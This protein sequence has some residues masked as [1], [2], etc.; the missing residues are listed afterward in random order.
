[1]SGVDSISFEG[2]EIEAMKHVKMARKCIDALRAK[3]GASGAVTASTQM[4]VSDHAYVIALIGPGIA[5]A[6]IVAGYANHLAPSINQRAISDVPDFVS[7][8][9]IRSRI[10]T[11]G[12]GARSMQ[13]FWPT[14][15][16]A[17]AFELSDDPAPIAR[18][19]VEPDA[20]LEAQWKA[21]PAGFVPAQTMRVVPTMY[22]GKMRQVVQC[23]LGFGREPERSR[24]D[25]EPPLLTRYG[26]DAERQNVPAY[27]RQVAQ[28]GRVVSY[29]WSFARTHGITVGADDTL[30][31]I[32]ISVQRGVIAMQLPTNEVTRDPR[33]RAKLE[34]MGDAAGLT[35]LDAFGAWP[36]GEPFPT[37]DA[38]EQARRGG[39]VMQ[40]LAPAALDPMYENYSAYS[41]AMGWS[42]DTRGREAHATAWRYADDRIQRGAWFSI[43]ITIGATAAVEVPPE[44]TTIIR[45]IER[46]VIA[47]DERQWLHRKAKRMTREQC[48]AVLQE[49]S[50]AG[51]LSA[52]RALELE[53]AA[54]ASATFVRVQEGPLYWPGLQQPWIQFAEPRLGYCVSHVMRQ[55]FGP[56]PRNPPRCDTVI[57]VLHHGDLLR[58]VRFLSDPRPAVPPDDDTFEACTFEGEWETVQTTGGTYVQ[59]IMVTSDVDDRTEASG[60]E[61]RV[62]LLSTS[63]GY[64]TV[65]VVDDLFNPSLGQMRRIRSFRQRHT[66]ST[67]SGPGIL[68]VIRVPFFDRSAYYYAFGTAYAIDIY[69]ES[70]GYTQLVDPIQ[71]ATWRNFAGYTTYSG[72][73][74]T[75]EHPAGCGAVVARTVWRETRHFVQCSDNSDQGSWASVCD[76]A[77]A[78]VYNTPLPPLPS[79]V[80]RDRSGV[81]SL[82]VQLFNASQQSPISVVNE[83]L[84]DANGWSY[85]QWFATSPDPETLDT[86]YM[87][88][89]ANAMGDR[90]QTVYST[91]PNGPTA[92]AGRPMHDAMLDAQCTYVGVVDG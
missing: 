66:T 11:D 82:R 50:G 1:M 43:R 52:L 4:R 57:H 91:D 35:V 15:D 24:Y 39:L 44:A 38:L 92:I 68:G 37:G 69:T 70:W 73:V 29:D 3:L 19:A 9:A 7:G 87:A 77:D 47:G 2:D 45:R 61:H 79:A 17:Q 76:D 48:Q 32:E 53:P 5:K 56:P 75:G 74:P 27:E 22:S 21:P 28:L 81:A 31:L 80:V 18:L 13:Q 46:Q 49:A 60:Y 72:L 20:T 6:V 84:I 14:S 65:Q 89:T 33:F 64:T 59:P 36:T 83:S 63:I 55:Q 8:V 78:M 85:Q 88:A 54:Q 71:Y 12:T 62:S 42:F 67:R 16:C 58:T 25:R 41:T 86:Q 26:R 40:L 10:V 51:V 90:L 23:L 34:A 30:W